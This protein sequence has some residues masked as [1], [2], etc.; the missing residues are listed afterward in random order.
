MGIDYN[1]KLKSRSICCWSRSNSLRP[2]VVGFQWWI[3]VVGVD[4]MIWIWQLTNKRN[5]KL[6]KTH[7]H[8]HYYQAANSIV[9]MRIISG[10]NHFRMKNRPNP[11]LINV[12]AGVKAARS[13]VT[14]ICLSCP[15]WRGIFM[16]YSR[17]TLSPSRFHSFI[18]TLIAFC[19]FPHIHM[20]FIFYRQHITV[21]TSCYCHICQRL[22]YCYRII[23]II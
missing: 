2:R 9:G 13:G 8:T 16:P 12:L 4:I 11:E 18:M 6:I 10:T 19:F 3:I 22:S 21:Q 23:F 1:G 17:P 15:L 7:T 20:S 5:Y 14:K